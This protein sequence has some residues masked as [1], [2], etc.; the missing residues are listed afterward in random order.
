[1]HRFFVPQDQIK[2][3]TITI[4]GNDTNH[5]KNVLRLSEKDVIEVFDSSGNIYTS[6]IKKIEP[7]KISC[8]ISGIKKE[9]IEPQ[10][11]I[12]L[13]QCLPKGKKMDMIIQKA[14]ELGVFNIIP[15]VSE[16]TIPKI[17]EKSDKKISHWQK[18][19]KE[20]SQQS[21]RSIVPQIKSLTKFED[22]V[23]PSINYNFKLIPWEGEKNNPLKEAVVVASQNSE[24][25]QQDHKKILV[26]IG[27]EGGFSQEEVKMANANNFISVSL[28]KRILRVET[29]A[30]V[31][32]AQLF[33]D[34]E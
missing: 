16:R 22:I 8:V 21:G 19:A 34:F 30:I 33:Y 28:G 4:K 24:P 32:L 31:I 12:T 26:L 25:L 1:M 3:G 17:E 18:I 2:N 6:I 5:I 15:V 7:D 10:T 29:A 27:P 13:A 23:K 11:K 20:A 14:T 9:E